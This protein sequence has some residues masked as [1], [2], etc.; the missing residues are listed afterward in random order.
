MFHC[1]L[2]SA[3]KAAGKNQ[4]TIIKWK[5]HMFTVCLLYNFILASFI[6]DFILKCIEHKSQFAI[7]CIYIHVYILLEYKF[8]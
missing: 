2:I 6:T 5:L 4:V 8:K 3:D 1:D 7:L